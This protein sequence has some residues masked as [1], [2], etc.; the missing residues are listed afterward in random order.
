MLADERMQPPDLR[1]AVAHRLEQP[2]QDRHR[3]D[4][5]H[6]IAAL[7]HLVE[8][9]RVHPLEQADVEQELPILGPE[10]REQARLHPVLDELA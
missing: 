6:R 1:F 10:A 8:K 4:P 2:G 7:Q 5:A 3:V 9:R